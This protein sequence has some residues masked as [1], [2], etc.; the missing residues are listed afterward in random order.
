MERSSGLQRFRIQ[1]FSVRKNE[2]VRQGGDVLRSFPGNAAPEEPFSRN[3]AERDRAVL[4]G[5]VRD[6][7]AVVQIEREGA[8][9][10]SG[11]DDPVDMPD[12][13]RIDE[14]PQRLGRNQG[15]FPE[16]EV[17]AAV[18]RNGDFP[19]L[20]GSFVNGAG[21]EIEPLPVR[22]A[23]GVFAVN[24]RQDG[25]ADQEQISLLIGPIMIRIFQ[26]ERAE[27]RA[28]GLRGT[29]GERIIVR[30]QFH[31]QFR[32]EAECLV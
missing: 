19:D 11:I 23:E 5:T 12:G 9:L 10:F 15:A 7:V 26:T 13:F 32:I 31:A 17:A 20:S 3:A 6:G 29:V 28:S 1:L 14:L 21:P 18:L 24:I 8:L 4:T 27:N 25:V 22:E 2:I 30:N 16:E